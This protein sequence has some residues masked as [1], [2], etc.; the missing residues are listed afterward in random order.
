MTPRE[1]IAEAWAI[2]TREAPLRR[3]GFFSSLLETLFLAKLVIYQSWFLY[4]FLQGNPIGFFDDVIWLS[5]HVS[6]TALFSIVGT[7]L[8]LLVLEWILPNFAKGA[9]VGLAAKS[10][11]KEEVKGGLVLAVYNFFPMFGIHEMF[12][13]AS[14][15]TTITI[16]SVLMRYISGDVKYYMIAIILLFWLFTNLLKFMASF[17]E[18]AVVIQRV[19]VFNAIGQS[20]KLILSY[21]GHVMFLWLLLCVISIRVAFNTVIVLFIPAIALGV[22]FVLTNVFAVS[23]EATAIAAVIIGL[24]L[25]L[26]ASYFFAYLHVFRDAV[27]TITYF[28]LKKQRDLV[29]IEE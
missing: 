17:A 6:T 18:P 20:F 21:L 26:I 4:S 7:F 2:T 25:I 14:L 22:G 15:P 27:W 19:S 3:W 13:L 10:Y 5:Q 29:L 24:I 8:F 12:F 9:I 28:E 23:L 1:I 11:R 16:C